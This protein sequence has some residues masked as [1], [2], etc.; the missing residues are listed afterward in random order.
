VRAEKDPAAKATVAKEQALPL[1]KELV[2]CVKQVYNSLLQTVGTTGEMGTVMNWEEHILP[3][4][5]EKPG[6]ELA[7]ALGEPLPADA[8]PSA[9]Y[10]GPGHLMVSALRTAVAAGE[11]LKL[12]LRVLSATPLQNVLVHW[13]ELGGKAFRTIPAEH[14]A[15]G[16]YTATFPAAK[17][18]FEYW[19]E[20]TS[21]GP[22]GC[23]F[24][25]TAPGMNQTVIVMPRGSG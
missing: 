15:R 25:A 20:S 7:Q 17:T 24:P 5:L 14:V 4:L 8:M 12:T 6:A 2:A 1:R 22:T 10:D 16:V 3:N 11:R 23:V 18:D 19:V 21:T 9:G 13:R